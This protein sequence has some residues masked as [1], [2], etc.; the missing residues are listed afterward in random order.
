MMVSRGGGREE[1]PTH[2]DAQVPSL[3]LSRLG[4]TSG[5]VL[6]LDVGVGVVGWGWV[7]RMRSMHELIA[8]SISSSFARL[9]PTHPMPKHSPRRHPLH[10]GHSYTR[11]GQADA[12]PAMP[13]QT[14]QH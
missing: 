4:G 8:N 12:R 2:A 6:S 14:P 5:A 10:T 7:G 9:N 11:R 1:E 13:P 3:S